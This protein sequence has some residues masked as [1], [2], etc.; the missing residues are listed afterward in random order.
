VPDN[1]QIR[2]PN[3][4]RPVV[5]TLKHKFA[6]GAHVVLDGKSDSAVFKVT[7]LLPDEGSGLQYRIK[8]EQEGHER[9]SVER[10]LKAAHR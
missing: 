7:R 6:L 8:N 10:L 2:R 9:V 1:S 3:Y 4:A 5:A